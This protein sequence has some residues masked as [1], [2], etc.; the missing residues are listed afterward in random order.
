MERYLRFCLKIANLIV[1]ERLG[2][3]HNRLL[4]EIIL[5]KRKTDEQ[6]KDDNSPPIYP[7]HR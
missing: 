4:L 6:D 2:I 3:F 1:L 5:T 7:H